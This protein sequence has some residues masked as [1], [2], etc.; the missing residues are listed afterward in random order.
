[1]L[2]LYPLKRHLLALRGVLYLGVHIEVHCDVTQCF[3]DGDPHRICQPMKVGVA[4]R[5]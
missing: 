2:L 4:L 5:G 3:E 1:M